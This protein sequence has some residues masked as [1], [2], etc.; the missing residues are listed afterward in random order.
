MVDDADS[1]SPV[2]FHRVAAVATAAV[3][4]AS[5]ASLSASIF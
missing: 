5:A 4:T 1:T 2:D 3:A